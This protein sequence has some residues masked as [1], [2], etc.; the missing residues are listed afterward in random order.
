MSLGGSRRGNETSRGRAER[1][2]K[3]K[4]SE[5]SKRRFT[6][7]RSPTE[8]GENDGLLF[9]TGHKKSRRRCNVRSLETG[10]LREP[11]TLRVSRNIAGVCG[12]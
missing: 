1:R 12:P 2:R 5:K 11:G 3:T 8:T 4:E 6:L 10:R 9:Y 7:L